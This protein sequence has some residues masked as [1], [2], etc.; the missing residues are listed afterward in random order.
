M[1]AAT[2]GSPERPPR[3][4]RALY[5]ALLVLVIFLIAAV[6]VWIGENLLFHRGR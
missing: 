3:Q 6:V 1:I 2:E 5:A 4:L